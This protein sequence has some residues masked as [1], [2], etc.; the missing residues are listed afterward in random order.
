MKLN[1]ISRRDFLKMSGTATAGWFISGCGLWQMVAHAPTA[2]APAAAPT[3]APVT[4]DL[5]Q[6]MTYY[7]GYATERDMQWVREF[8]I[9]VLV[10][11][12]LLFLN[13]N[14]S[15]LPAYQPRMN[16]CQGNGR[17]F[18][19]AIQAAVLAEDAHALPQ[20]GAGDPALEFPMDLIPQW[21][22]LACCTPDD[23]SMREVLRSGFAHSCINN[24]Q[25]REFFETKLRGIIDSGADGVH[26]DELPTRYFARQE[27][28]C[29]ACMAGLRDYL[30][31]KY[32]PADLDA[33]Y[34]IDD[35]NTFDFRQR[36]AEEGNLQKPPS[37]PLHREWWL[38]QLSNL[39]A[40]ESELLASCASYAQSKGRRFYLTSNAYEPEV[41]P[42]H[43][44]EMT[45]TD[46]PSIGT[47]LTIQLRQG[48]KLASELRI[49]PDYSYIPL[50][51]MAQS[52][53]PGKPITL[54]IDGP[55]GTSTIKALPEQKQ[56]D[57]V[58]WMFAEAYAS[59][60]R[61]HIPYPSLDYY[62]P[63]DE[64]KQYAHFIQDNPELF[65]AASPLADVGVLFSYASEIWDY[66]VQAGSASPNHN[67]QWYGLAQ[68][69]TDMSVQYQAIFAPDGGVIANR[70]ALEELLR[71]QT[72]IVPWAYA[73]SD[74]HVQLLQDY[75]RHGG[76]LLI[77]GD[78]ATH[79]EEKRPRSASVAEAFSQ[80][81]AVLLPK[82]DFEAYL[83][84]P[85]KQAVLSELD[86]LIV[87][88]L[89]TV[90]NPSITAQLNRTQQA[91]VCHLVNKALD[92]TGF[93]PQRDVKLSIN[94][95]PGLGLAGTQVLLL[96]PDQAGGGP[97]PLEPA[98]QGN[99]IEIT[100]P[101]IQI[102]SLL[103]IPV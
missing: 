52:V 18:L 28:Y 3:A 35:I 79:D 67:R 1:P 87:D 59:G 37:S 22:T 100:L 102:Y 39:V 23:A 89:A 47:G 60:A 9:D 86:S 36:L 64:C 81:G 101:E 70:L 15:W 85:G 34:G 80:L 57:I 6:A 38:F 58:R 26:I 74:A 13:S 19:V 56:K 90:S 43:V 40:V 88:R 2:T 84:D 17:L 51:R 97:V 91:L 12:F 95:P 69:L 66:W 78:L 7:S 98:R 50:Y 72:L 24:L 73:L 10:R 93:K 96:S 75:A 103:V 71:Y 8:D 30:A 48:R 5:A 54:F 77:A 31:R 14:D 61:F 33:L 68:A 55:G 29:D 76:R 46:F 20:L 82:L 49:P 32:S 83:N 99:A 44:I 16:E 45:L 21:E 63:L 53:A 62:A 11:G 92:E 27:G 94:M 4:I 25:F 65:Q 42:N 41:N